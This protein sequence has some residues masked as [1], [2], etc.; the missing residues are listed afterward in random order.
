M[1][2]LTQ[3]EIDEAISK[4]E[5]EKRFKADFRDAFKGCAMLLFGLLILGFA[6]GV[7]NDDKIVKRE[8]VSNSELDASVWQVESY[9]KS[10]YLK[11]PDSY[12]AIEWSA[13]VIDSTKKEGN[14]KYFVRHKYRA[15]N[16]FGGYVIEN[17][18]FYLDSSGTVINV[19]ESW[20]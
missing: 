8:N 11:D 18:V 12:E 9:L 15:R 5:K 10:N 1:S 16:S 4:A 13:V 19:T 7:C 6:C 2:Y 17:K 14:Y 3:K 20:R